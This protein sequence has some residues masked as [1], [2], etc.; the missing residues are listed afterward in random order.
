M[1]IIQQFQNTTE[2]QNFGL[3][4]EKDELKIRRESKWEGLA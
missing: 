2:K 3:I 1:L 4:S